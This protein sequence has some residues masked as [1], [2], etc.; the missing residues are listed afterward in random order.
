MKDRMAA[1]QEFLDRDPDDAFT[2]YAL[3][4]EHFSRGDVAIAV[5]MLQETLERD[6][7]YVPAYHQLALALTREAATEEAIAWY[8]RGIAVA[9]ERNERH[10]MDEMSQELEDLLADGA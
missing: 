10:A 5:T 7:T 1:L 6:P 9:R 2:R 3:A 8:K 4:L